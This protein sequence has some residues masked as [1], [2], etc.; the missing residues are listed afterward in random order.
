MSKGILH[1]GLKR[2]NPPQQAKGDPKSATSYS[3]LDSDT[4]R[5]STQP[6]QKPLPGRTA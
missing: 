6:N 1:E 4:T 2:T 3:S 5:G